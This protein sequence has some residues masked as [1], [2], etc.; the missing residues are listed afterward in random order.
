MMKSKRAGSEQRSIPV[1]GAEPNCDQIGQRADGLG[2]G[3]SEKGAEVDDS[4][5]LGLAAGRADDRW[6][7]PS[8]W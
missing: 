1:A 7:W 3:R 4:H 6:P 8:G 2:A 5:V